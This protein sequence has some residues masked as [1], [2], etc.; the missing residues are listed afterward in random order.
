MLCSQYK[1]YSWIFGEVR[2][3]IGFLIVTWESVHQY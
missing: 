3:E 1:Q 2:C